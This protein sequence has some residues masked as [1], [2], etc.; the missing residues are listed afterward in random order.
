M[1]FTV[2]EKF[3]PF[4]QK[5]Y[6]DAFPGNNEYRVLGYVNRGLKYIS[7]ALN[8][9]V[10]DPGYWTSTRLENELSKF[11]CVVIHYL[12]PEFIDAISRIPTN[13]MIVW[14]GWG[15]DYES[16]LE[17]QCGPYVLALTRAMPQRDSIFQ[18]VKPYL[19]SPLQLSKILIEKLQR[20]RAG[21]YNENNSE[22]I[23]RIAHRFN[24]VSVTPAEV[25]YMINAL[26]QYNNNIN[27][28]TLHY[29][30]TE[31]VFQQG[32]I[33]ME[34]DHILI[35]NSASP[36]NNHIEAFEYLKDIDTTNRKIIVPLSY[37][38]KRYAEAIIRN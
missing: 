32:P 7:P 22:A 9:K 1:H 18:R 31:T 38:P 23:K 11:D 27:Y 16:L 35:G 29:Y 21:F 19:A 15:G 14:S 24:V 3:I 5:V 28:H 37:G 4:V 13:V 17:P 8:V 33:K 26:S 20:P 30:C 10:A 2:D 36:T 25:P 12:A 6:E 34:G